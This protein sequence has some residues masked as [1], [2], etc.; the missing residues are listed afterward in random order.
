MEGELRGVLQSTNESLEALRDAH[1][2]LKKAHAR[3]AEKLAA[4][5]ARAQEAEAA[6]ERTLGECRAL[7]ADWGAQL[8]AQALEFKAVEAQ[9]VPLH[10]VQLAR[11][12]AADDLR[13]AH[14]AEVADLQARV[15][16]ARDALH[17]S[18]RECQSARAQLD[19]AVAERDTCVRMRDGQT[20]QIHECARP[21][22]PVARYF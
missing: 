8:N 14:S 5:E 12:A 1:E 9:M 20:A 18:R 6:R 2:L 17:Q 15:D 4:A 16:A 3:Q 10:Q 7:Y 11:L 13:Q 21:P 19:D 22:R